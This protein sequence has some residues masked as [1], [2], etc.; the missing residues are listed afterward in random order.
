MGRNRG[1]AGVQARQ[2]RERARNIGGNSSRGNGRCLDLGG[3]PC[4]HGCSYGHYWHW[5]GQG[6]RTSVPEWQISFVPRCT[7]DAGLHAWDRRAY[8]A[9]QG[10]HMV[11]VIGHPRPRFCT[12]SHSIYLVCP[13]LVCRLPRLPRRRPMWCCPAIYFS[14]IPKAA[15]EQKHI[16]VSVPHTCVSLALSL[17]PCFSPPEPSPHIGC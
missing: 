10:G 16:A 2:G 6:A 1:G 13:C 17:D 4:R 3:L 7:C 15:V 12:A 9:M 8:E 14:A 5:G 11:L